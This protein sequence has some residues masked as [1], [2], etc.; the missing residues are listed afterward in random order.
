MKKLIGCLLFSI[1]VF[2]ANSQELFLE[3]GKVKSKFD[4]TTSDGNSLTDLSGSIQN[5]IGLGFRYALFETSLHV[6][7]AAT[8]NKFEAKGRDDILDNNYEWYVEYLGA[9]LGIDYEFF[10]PHA[11]YVKQ[12]GFSI[13]VRAI[14]GVDFLMNGTQRLNAQIINLDGKEEFDQPV[15]YTKGALGVNYYLSSVY[16]IILQY[17][18][19]RSFLVGDY[20]NEEQ[21]RYLTHNISAGFSITLF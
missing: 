6:S 18:Y 3:A 19:G 20:E 9:N 10:K 1:I 11:S 17:T 2:S 4:Y 8:Y 12:D 15:Y 13:Y 21:L 14:F 7:A 16:K 5:S